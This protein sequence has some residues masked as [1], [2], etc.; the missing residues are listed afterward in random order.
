MGCVLSIG[1]QPTS[2]LSVSTRHFPSLP[3]RLDFQYRA[4]LFPAKWPRR[5]TPYLWPP[6]LLQNGNSGT[7]P[8]ELFWKWNETVFISTS[9]S[10][11][12]S[13][14]LA[15]QHVEVTLVNT[16]VLSE[17]AWHEKDRG[18]GAQRPSFTPVR[19]TDSVREDNNS[20]S[21]NLMFAASFNRHSVFLL[22]CHQKNKLRPV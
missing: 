4:H 17:G 13:S 11:S 1:L 8:E 10:L 6:F 14:A 12:P 5:A 2:C 19:T 22:L 16:C 15:L 9:S 7:C 21:S 18:L 20:R 3:W